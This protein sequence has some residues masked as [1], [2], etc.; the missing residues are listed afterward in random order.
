M[1]LQLYF[2]LKSRLRNIYVPNDH[3][4]GPFVVITNPIL[5]L[6]MT[7][8]TRVTPRVPLVEQENSTLPAY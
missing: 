4:Y 8:H 3:G 5:S 7:Y 1:I 2:H 6:F